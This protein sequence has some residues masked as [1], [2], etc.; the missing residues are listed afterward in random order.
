MV[1]SWEPLHVKRRTEV[2]KLYIYIFFYFSNFGDNH[3]V[4]NYFV[5]VWPSL[6][7]GR[8]SSVEWNRRGSKEAERGHD[9]AQSGCQA[10]KGSKG[11]ENIK[12]ETSSLCIYWNPVI[13]QYRVVF[14]IVLI[15][16]FHPLPTN[17]MT[18][19]FISTWYKTMFLLYMSSSTF[20][21]DRM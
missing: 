5:S 10:D 13:K 12:Y 4:Y 21:M 19:H 2:F 3:F 17:K 9:P 1:A 7:Q 11:K 16:T 20:V 8:R 6:L 18:S 14:I 15:L